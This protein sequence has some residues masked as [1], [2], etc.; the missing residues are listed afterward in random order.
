MPAFPVEAVDTTAAGDVFNGALAVRVAEGV[1]A[2]IDAIRFASAAAA[3]SV[4]KLGAQPSAP[5]RSEIETFL[6][7]QGPFSPANT[8]RG[9]RHG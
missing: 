5:Q 9:G 1:D 2:W 8:L 4:M 7:G 6:G 3:L